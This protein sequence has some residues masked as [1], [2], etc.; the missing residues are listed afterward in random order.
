[1]MI[2]VVAVALAGLLCTGCSTPF[3]DRDLDPATGLYV[4]VSLVDPDD[5]R[6]STPFARIDEVQFVFL[7][8][9]RGVREID[10]E[11]FFRRRLADYGFSQVLNEAEFTQKIISTNLQKSISRL[12]D[13]MSLARAAE[14]FG[15]F[16]IVETTERVVQHASTHV[17]TLRV[18]DPISRAVLLDIY[19]EK[20]N[21]L[22]Y[23]DA[24]AYPLQNALKSWIDASR[25]MSEA[26]LDKTAAR[27]P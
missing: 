27:S 3:V 25:A 20:V 10:L 6:I 15:P 7:R 17:Q 1:M 19:R 11:D 2:K 26:A 22:G 13:S 24:I 23:D 12:T 9:A 18:T 5:I 21:W 16:L 8:T 14:A 4:G